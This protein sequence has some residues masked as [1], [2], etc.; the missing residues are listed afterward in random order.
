M[1]VEIQKAIFGK[2]SQA[3]PGLGCSVYGA[4]APQNAAVPYVTIGNI[5]M[6]RDDT[7]TIVG[8]NSTVTIH[9]WGTSLLIVMQILDRVKEILHDAVLTIDDNN[10]AGCLFEESSVF[11]DEDEKIRHGVLVFRIWAH[12]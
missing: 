9:I 6:A 3:S 5:T 11:P 12:A 4:L 8:V 10:A 1:L 7:F 2:L